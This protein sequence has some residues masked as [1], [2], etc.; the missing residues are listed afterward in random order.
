M[1]TK[2]IEF[3][4]SKDFKLIKE[5]GQG[6]T[7]RTVLLKDDIIDEVF[8]CKKY[9]PFHEEYKESLFK[10]FVDEIKILHKLY[11][12][13]IVRVFNYYLYPE[14]TT[15]YILMEYIKGT[16]ISTFVVQ[17]PHLINDLFIQTIN[18]FKYLEDNNI[19]HRDIRS[20]NILVS[21]EGFLKIIDFGF[22]K[23]VKF[24]E[25]FDKSISL[26]WQYSPPADFDSKFYDFRTEI[27][28]VGKLF[29]E[30][31]KN[32]KIE[33]FSYMDILGEMVKNNF[34][35]RIQTFALI[36][37][38]ILSSENIEID[39][40]EE[41]KNIYRDFADNIVS[42][43]SKIESNS[44]YKTD[45]DKIVNEL[46]NVYQNSILEEFIQNTNSIARCFVEGNYYY[47]K[48][49]FSLLSLKNFIKF[50]RSLSFD[51]KRIVL[52]NLWQRL[53]SIN[54]Y[55]ENDNVNDDLPF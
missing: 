41:E 42:I 7:G 28:F 35:E 6:G 11:H 2:V 9:A 26:N 33:N 18:G 49:E 16:D 45:I 37:R 29:E 51:R 22:G 46:G 10:F 55:T 53:D 1:N 4:R 14:Q 3:I 38:K 5:I 43:F 40:T 24:E 15:G 23:Q 17:N 34:E 36:E 31:I 44:N 20:Q 32:N 27:Y 50:L 30:I 48:I 8:V 21:E 25:D 12:K 19:L 54:R 47:R 39:F 52:N 13:N